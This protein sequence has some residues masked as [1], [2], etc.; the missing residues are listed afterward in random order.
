MHRATRPSWFL[1]GRG[2]VRLVLGGRG[3]P[4]LGDE[5]LE[6]DAGHGLLHEVTQRHPAPAAALRPRD[7]QERPVEA[8]LEITSARVRPECRLP[9]GIAVAEQGLARNGG[10][11]LACAPE[12]QGSLHLEVAEGIDAERI[13]FDP[14]P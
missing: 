4:A 1:G 7:D 9:G 3:R 8:A 14:G 2:D 6:G 12:C 13:A 11:A 10:V 5:R